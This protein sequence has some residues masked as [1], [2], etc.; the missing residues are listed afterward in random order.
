MCILSSIKYTHGN[1]RSDKVAFTFDCLTNVNA[2]LL[3]VIKQLSLYK[4]GR[5]CW[6]WKMNSKKIQDSK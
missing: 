1:N 6:L 4:K 2:L 5:E 3:G